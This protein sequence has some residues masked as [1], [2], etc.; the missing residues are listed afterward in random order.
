[1][2]QNADVFTSTHFSHPE[3]RGSKLLRNVEETYYTVYEY[4]R[5][6]FKDISYDI[7]IYICIY[8]YIPVHCAVTDV[9]MQCTIDFILIN[10]A[11]TNLRDV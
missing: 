3:H 1:M 9:L 11:T 7:Y 6:P 4:R 2:L 5:P 10:S 8:I